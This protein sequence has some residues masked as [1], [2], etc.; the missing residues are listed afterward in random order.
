[1][2]IHIARKLAKKFTNVFTNFFYKSVSRSSVRCTFRVETSTCNA[3]SRFFRN[4]LCISDMICRVC[5][6]RCVRAPHF[7]IICNSGR[8]AP[9]LGAFASPRFLPFYRPF[10]I[11][12][13]PSPLPSLFHV[14]Y[15]RNLA[16]NFSTNVNAGRDGF[17]NCFSLPPPTADPFYF[18]VLLLPSL[19]PLSLSFSYLC[20]HPLFFVLSVLSFSSSHLRV[21]VST[22]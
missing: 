18:A 15:V 4:I 7:Y 10:L 1:M 6:P 16:E 8:L 3:Y 22:L 19:P 21:Y 11:F 2:T 14:C 5:L 20:P 17:T 13:F 12:S 9:P